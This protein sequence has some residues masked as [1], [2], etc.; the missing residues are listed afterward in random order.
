MSAS[1]Q[2]PRPVIPSW[3][4]DRFKA[5]YLNPPHY[6]ASYY[7]PANMLLTTYF[8]ASL[9]FLVKPQARLREPPQPAERHSFDSYG[10]PVGTSNKDGN[11][12]FLVS[13][14]TSALDGDIPFLIYELK[15]DDVSEGEAMAQMER[16]IHWARRY[17]LQLVSPSE[18]HIY[19]LLVF[20]EQ[21]QIFGMDPDATFTHTG[22]RVGTTDDTILTLFH[23]LRSSHGTW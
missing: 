19:A 23:S 9:Q 2:I 14:G 10:Q 16:Y 4:L 20:G 6:E 15:R 7:G 11:P 3:L 5:L 13:R 12:D 8:P 21:T 1:R 18:L 17:Q 22:P